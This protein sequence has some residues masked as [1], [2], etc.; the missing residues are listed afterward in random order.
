[1]AKR[2][3]LVIFDIDG[4]L[5]ASA[6]LHHDLIAGVLAK[7][8]LD[9]LF[10]PWSAY[11]NYTDRGV[12]DELMRHVRGRAAT[13]ADI[14]YYDEAY[15]LA[16]TVHLSENPIPEVP[17][18]R[19]LLSELAAMPDVRMSFA[20]GSLRKMAIMKLRLLGVYGETAALATGTDHLSREGIVAASIKQACGYLDETFDVVL[21]GDGVW[22]E[23]T[24]VNLGIPFVAVQSGT[25]VFGDIPVLKVE[26][27]N[28]LRAD[29]LVALARPLQGASIRAALK[30][31]SK[32]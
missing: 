7:D 31:R 20:T 16:L 27:F 4:T 24:A 21:L 22:D 3:T 19:R 25:H 11:R 12:L 9:V 6:G 10:Q 14:E 26:D 23:R 15:R 17:G 29:Q 5:L 32:I 13:V 2:Q 30:E 1:M 28:A 18:A 8:G